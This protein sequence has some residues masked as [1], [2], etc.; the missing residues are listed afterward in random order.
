MREIIHGAGSIFFIIILGLFIMTVSFL[1]PQT[2]SPHS[3]ETVSHH[4]DISQ[5]QAI[6]RSV[7]SAVRVVS[8][9]LATGGVAS[10]SGT[11]FEFANKFYVLTS[12]HGV[13]TGCEGLM[14]FHYDNHTQCTRLVKID[15]EVDYAIFEVP[16]IESR[17]PIKVPSALANWRKSYNLLDK[18]YYTGYP[19]SIGPT[20]WTGNISGFTGD[21]LII[22]TY[23]WSGAS[24]SG[25]FDERGEL[26]G[27]IMALDVG[28]TEYGY[29]VLNNFVIVVPIWQVDFGS[30]QE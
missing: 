11:Y 19:N 25:V 23:A 6:N 18:T 24:G 27:L 12:A 20:T 28:A 14:V 21:Y 16:E 9:D 3:Y 26:I 5:K 17:T 13:L 10:L 4:Y 7:N 29:Q 30:L 22:Q 8:M 1:H 2:G 15:R